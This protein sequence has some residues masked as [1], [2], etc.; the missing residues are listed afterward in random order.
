MNRKF[1][2]EQFAALMT[3]YAGTMKMPDAKIEVYWEMLKDLPQ[4]EFGE[5]VKEWLSESKWFPTIAELGDLTLP[6]ITELTPYNSH[7]PQKEI[8][9]GWRAQVERA[10]LAALPAPKPVAL[11][12]GATQCDRCVKLEAINDELQKKIAMLELPKITEGDR[13]A[14]REETRL[15]LKQQAEQ[16]LGGG[17]AAAKKKDQQPVSKGTGIRPRRSRAARN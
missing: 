3:A 1:F 15:R 11:L 13:I 2:N 6:P 17:N 12:P 8:R 14:A 10:K 5:A 16:L 7:T 9:I 4:A